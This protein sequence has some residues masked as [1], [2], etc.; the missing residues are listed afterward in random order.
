M[1]FSN[2]SVLQKLRVSRG[3]IQV[4]TMGADRRVLS[5]QQGWERGTPGSAQEDMQALVFRRK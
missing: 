2:G 1:A 4:W 5:S 3:E